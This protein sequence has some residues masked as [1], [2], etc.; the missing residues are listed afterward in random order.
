MSLGPWCAC[1]LDS[2]G[3]CGTVRHSVLGRVARESCGIQR[4][5]PPTAPLPGK[6]R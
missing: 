1:P 3:V 5:V 6:E 4:A 2:I